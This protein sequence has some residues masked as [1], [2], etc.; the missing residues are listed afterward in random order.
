MTPQARAIAAF[1]IAVLLVMGQL[2]RIVAA[3]VV[4]FGDSYP[5]GRGGAFLTSLIAVAIAGLVT[6][7]A[8]SAVGLLASSP[9]WENHLARA[10]V[11]VALIGLMIA[12]L[13]GIA[14]V[15]NSSGDMPGNGGFV[16][17]LFY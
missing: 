3:F 15:A 12:V 8:V 1:T 6:F 9:G 4:A 17:Y 7:N 13:T 10:A 16:P 2:N 11:L 5:S 14:A